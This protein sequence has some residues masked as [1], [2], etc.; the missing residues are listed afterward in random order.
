MRGLRVFGLHSCRIDSLIGKE[1]AIFVMKQHIPAD[2]W[3]CVV[4]VLTN[5]LTLNLSNDEIFLFF[6]CRLL[7]FGLGRAGSIEG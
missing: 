4:Y 1:K 2:P 7:Y 6:T 3:E 5:E